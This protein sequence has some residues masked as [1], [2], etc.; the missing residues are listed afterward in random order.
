MQ[1]PP[2]HSTPLFLGKDYWLPRLAHLR[3][4]PRQLT[5]LQRKDLARPG[6]EVLELTLL[7]HDG[8]PLQAL[9]ARSTFHRAGRAVHLRTCCGLDTCA[10]DW[11]AVE[12]GISDL[13]FAFPAE[14][15][16]E[17]RV[18]DVLRLTQVAA[19]LESIPMSKVSLHCG[20]RSAPDE[21]RIANL[22]LQQSWD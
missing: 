11:R 12:R 9:L 2:N 14:H 22:V 4:S 6:I 15:N 21:F 8:A 1:G 7:S 10:I 5:Q 16:L 17:A 19:E 13:V 3:G 18:L 20:T